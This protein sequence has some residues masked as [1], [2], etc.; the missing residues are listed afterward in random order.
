VHE[1]PPPRASVTVMIVTLNGVLAQGE[2][3][4][5]FLLLPCRQKRTLELN[6]SA[7]CSYMRWVERSDT[8]QQELKNGRYRLRLDPPYLANY[9]FQ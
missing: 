7:F 5:G 1:N 3:A 2:R 9:V 4:D 6:E 8:R